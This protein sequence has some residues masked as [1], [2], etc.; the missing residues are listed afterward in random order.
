[1][2]PNGEAII[3]PGNVSGL[4]HYPQA[5]QVDANARTLYISGITGRRADGSIDGVSVNNNG[6][7]AINVGQQTETVFDNIEDIIKQATNDQGG[8]GN[9]VD[10]TIFLTDM[11][12]YKEMNAVWNR[13][14]PV[15][16][17]SPARTCVAVKALPSPQLIVEVK[18]VALVN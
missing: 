6:E 1:M 8:L 18:V 7:T 2:S 4:A 11:A 14:F 15:T 10:A 9:I 16:K 5:R 12:D 3:K 17:D 13:R